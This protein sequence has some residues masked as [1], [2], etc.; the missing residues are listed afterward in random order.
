MRC[1]K[2]KLTE[3]TQCET[4]HWVPSLC[5]FLRAMAC[6]NVCHRKLVMSSPQTCTEFSHIVMQ[7]VS[8]TCNI[9]PKWNLTDVQCWQE[10]YPS[11]STGQCDTWALAQKKMLRVLLQMLF[12]VS[13]S[14]ILPR[15]PLSHTHTKH[16]H[17]NV[18]ISSSFGSSDFY[19]TP[20]PLQGFIVEL[21]F[22]ITDCYI[23]TCVWEAHRLHEVRT[24]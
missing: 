7:P 15:Q 21:N 14:T 3:F 18:H 16:N 6:M 13:A 10:N 20:S 9:E 5:I 22:R 11:N 17:K 19:F 2:E 1:Y 12:L 23:D 8:A 4:S 24:E